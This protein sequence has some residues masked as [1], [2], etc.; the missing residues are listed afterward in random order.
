MTVAELRVPFRLKKETVSRSNGE[1]PWLFFRFRELDQ[2]AEWIELGGIALQDSG[3]GFRNWRLAA[4]MFAK[5][6]ERL[7]QAA[8]AIDLQF[9]CVPGASWP[10]CEIFGPPLDV[11]VAKVRNPG[12]VEW[13]AR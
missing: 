3:M 6:E 9:N 1:L 10:H 5:T 8:G 13:R 2:V 4:R 12:H 11:A 7:R